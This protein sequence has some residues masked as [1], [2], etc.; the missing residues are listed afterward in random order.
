MAGNEMRSSG[1]GAVALSPCHHWHMQRGAQF[2]TSDGWQ[3]P[4]RYPDEQPESAHRSGAGLVDLSS[5]VKILIQGVGVTAVARG[6][7]GNDPGHLLRRVIPL[8]GEGQ[9]LACRLSMERWLLLVMSGATA[10]RE[11]LA[12]LTAGQAVVT[13]DVTSA[14]AVFGL[15]GA[16]IDP[17]VRRLTGLDATFVGLPLGTCAETTLAGV[18]A[19]L[20]R[21]P[22]ELATLLVSVS[23]DLGEY[24]WEQL[25]EAGRGEVYPLGVERWRQLIR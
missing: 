17:V 16:Q 10:L 15:V 20:I 6:L 21:P 13:S 1:N 25:L 3:L 22:W 14:T 11:R 7:L 8:P 5:A 24:V 4:A 19:L 2:T 18:Q 12:N 23:W 9:G